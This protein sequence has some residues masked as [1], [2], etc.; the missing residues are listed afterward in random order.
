MKQCRHADC[1]RTRPGTAPEGPHRP[2]TRLRGGRDSAHSRLAHGGG[3]PTGPAGTR[4]LCRAGLSA[5]RARQPHRGRAARAQGHLLPAHCASPARAHHPSA[6]RGLDRD[7]QQGAS[8]ARRLPE[9]TR[10][11]V[12]RHRRSPRAFSA[13][14]IDGTEIRFTNVAKTVADCFKFRNKIGLDVALEAL[15][16]ALRGQARRRWTSCGAT[17]RIDRVANVMRPYLEA[18]A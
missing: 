18:V 3:G 17:R 16:E 2:V 14:R 9:A 6:L 8:A 5:G 11:A 12:L 15:R 10:C 1:R 13:R 4:P 7:R